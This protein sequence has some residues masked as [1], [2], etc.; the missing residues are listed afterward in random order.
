[1]GFAGKPFRPAGA[2]KHTLTSDSPPP[3]PCGTSCTGAQVTLVPTSADGADRGNPVMLPPFQTPAATTAPWPSKDMSAG[4]AVTPNS[5][6]V[7][8]IQQ[9]RPGLMYVIAARVNDPNAQVRGQ[10]LPGCPYTTAALAPL[11]HAGAPHPLHI[12]TQL[13]R[14]GGTWTNSIL[15]L[16]PA[17][18][19]PRRQRHLLQAGRQP[20]PAPPAAAGQRQ[21]PGTHHGR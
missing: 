13:G 4:S 3:T 17:G 15:I 12:D 14:Q 21:G 9:D 20:P 19:R 7:N 11:T 6:V 2:S 18:H 10:R 1:M 8:G 5:F 16:C